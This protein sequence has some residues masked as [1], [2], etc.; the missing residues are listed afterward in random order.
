MPIQERC[1]YVQGGKVE[2]V[3]EQK[4]QY[5]YD[6]Y[7]HEKHQEVLAVVEI[8]HYQEDRCIGTTKKICRN[9][10]RLPLTP[11][12]LYYELTN[13][14]PTFEAFDP[15]DFGGYTYN[16]ILAQIESSFDLWKIAE[17]D[18]GTD[19]G[20]IDFYFDHMNV[21]TRKL[22]EDT[23]RTIMKE[24]EFFPMGHSHRRGVSW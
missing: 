12:L 13:G 22:F 2:A 24:T 7:I 6:I 1:G 8:S 20:N 5:V 11:E 3:E 15:K 9:L 19:Y 21:K 23:M 18:V 14:F 16:E 10:E 4:N 17:Y